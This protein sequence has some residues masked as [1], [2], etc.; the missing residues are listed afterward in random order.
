MSLQFLWACNPLCR[1]T[2]TDLTLLYKK[3]VRE[4]AVSLQLLDAGLLAPDT[5]AARLQRSFDRCEWCL[6]HKVQPA[7]QIAACMRCASGERL[8]WALHVVQQLHV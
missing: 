4:L 7:P 3:T 5:C 8:A 2:C 6:L 1:L